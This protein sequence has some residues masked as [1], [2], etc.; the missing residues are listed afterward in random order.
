MLDLVFHLLVELNLEG[1]TTIILDLSDKTDNTT[2]PIE[3]VQ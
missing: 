1:I 3:C 2:T